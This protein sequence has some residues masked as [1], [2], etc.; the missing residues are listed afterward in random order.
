M[1]S[2]S[3]EPRR[4]DPRW[5]AYSA[6][7]SL[8]S[9]IVPLAIVGFSRRGSMTEWIGIGIAFAIAAVLLASRALAWT[10]IAYRVTER[11]IELHSGLLSRNE[12]FLPADRVQAIDFQEDV[13]HRLLGVVA[14]KVESA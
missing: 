12:R 6:V 7:R 9:L 3:S 13:I 14:I 11:G 5:I 10:R 8:R 1:I 4:L 2:E